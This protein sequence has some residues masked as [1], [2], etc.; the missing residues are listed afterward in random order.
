MNLTI[1]I[2]FCQSAV[3]RGHADVIPPD[4]WPHI[5]TYIYLSNSWQLCH[6]WRSCDSCQLS[7]SQLVP[8][9]LNQT[10]KIYFFFLIPTNTCRVQGTVHADTKSLAVYVFSY[11][12]YVLMYN[13]IIQH[14]GGAEHFQLFK[15]HNFFAARK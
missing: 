11:D 9:Y 13:S 7:Q 3:H 2:F 15:K 5:H 12:T 4:T 6:G 1:F 10:L 14:T 8:G